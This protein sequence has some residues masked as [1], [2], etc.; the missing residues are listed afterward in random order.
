[1]KT[2]ITPIKIPKYI[3]DAILAAKGDRTLTAWVIDAIHE[4]LKRNK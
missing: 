4:K 2:P 1:M 3:K